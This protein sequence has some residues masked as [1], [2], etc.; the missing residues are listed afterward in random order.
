MRET[1]KLPLTFDAKWLEADLGNFGDED[2][3]PHFNRDYYE[4]EWSGIA[5]R[6]PADA[7]VDLYPDPT[8]SH[9]VVTPL[10]G[11]CGYVPEVLDAFECELESAR[12]LR[13]GAGARIREHRDFKLSME[14]GV[15]RVHI[16]VVTD[17]A[18]SFFLN[19]NRVG[20]Q[21]GEAWYLN[22]NL[23]HRVE[24]ESTKARVHLVIDC[25]VND[26]FRSF[27]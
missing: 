18:V 20:M 8:A 26:W 3:T 19:G 11:R 25:V 6:S 27:F 23:P 24:N 10:L 22:F 12:F 5:L 2:W 4:G 16:P 9:Y 21:P 13:L 17:P 1:L 14:D 7:H 15:G